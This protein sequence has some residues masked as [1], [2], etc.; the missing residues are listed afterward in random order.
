MPRQR[1]LDPSIPEHID[2]RKLPAGCYWNRRDRNWYTIREGKRSKPIAQADAL[3]S[4]LHKAME[5]S[6]GADA[7]T[8]DY[9]LEKFED[10]GQFKNEISEATRDDYRYCR[11]A[12]QQH[13]TK[14]GIP[15]ASLRRA[16][17]TPPLIQR[18][19]NDI[20]AKKPSKAN[21]VAR[22]LSVAYQWGYLNGYADSNVARGVR[23]AKE[24]KAHRMP[25]AETARRV[26]AFLR[27]RGAMPSRRKGSV[28]PY[29]W[30]VAEIAYRC[31]MRS[32]EVRNLTDASATDA[33]VHVKRV[34]GSDANLTRWCPEL[35]EAWGWLIARRARI[36][37]KKPSLRAQAKR[38][39]V[40][41]EDGA[42][43]SK[44]A[45]N[46]AWRRAMDVAIE[47]EVIDSAE[48]FG[49]HGLKHRGVT[50]TPGRKAD[51]KAASGHKTDA[52]MTVYDHELQVVDAAGN[53]D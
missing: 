29:V 37:L 19:V 24:R 51:K 52:M 20:A 15:F 46:S 49:L 21:H 48:R 6:K 16:A 12:L 38:P 2:Q 17:I 10:S 26:V 34:K 53:R 5:L 40:V 7:S 9:M 44:S 27:A 41:S 47:A 39:L 42:A 4:D 43:L 25:E 14:L 18:L 31:R 13:P 30:A 8:L 50:D 36:W 28:A 45:L 33:G 32:V 3:L 35:R 23:Q 11:S 22:Y 1:K